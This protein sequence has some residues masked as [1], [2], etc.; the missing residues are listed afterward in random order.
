MSKKLLRAGIIVFVVSIIS[1]LLGFSKETL[2]A[3]IYGT[4]ISSDAYYI[5]LTPSTLAITFSLSLSG[6]FIPLFIR[7]LDQRNGAFRFLN[8]VLALF[9]FFTLILYAGLFLFQH[10]FLDLIAPGIPVEQQQLYISL[11]KIMFP[12][13]YIV[14]AV[15]IYTVVLN[16]MKSF[17]LPAI[18]ILPSNLLIILYLEVFK[19]KLGL[20][21]V[22]YATLISNVIQYV[23]LYFALKKYDYKIKL[24]VKFFDFKT[25]EFLLLLLPILM[26]TS[27]S[28][29]SA[30]VDRV[31]ASGLGE[32]SVSSL[33]YS[34]RLRGLATGVFITSIITVTFPKAAE[35]AHKL[36]VKKLEAFTKKCMVALIYVLAP[37]TIFFMV[38]SKEI[39]NLLFER[40]KFDQTATAM[41]SGIFFTYSIGLVAI[42]FREVAVRTFYTFKDTKTP[43]FIMVIS[44]ML[45]IVLSVVFTRFYGL[46]G[47]GLSASLSFI[48]TAIVMGYKLPKRLPNLWSKDF[49]V[50]HIKALCAFVISYLI[51]IFVRDSGAI[52][53]FHELNGIEKLIM[54]GVYFALSTV[55]FMLV[56]LV[57]REEHLMGYCKTIWMSRR[58]K[59]QRRDEKVENIN[60]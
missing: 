11:L 56:L 42:G 47:L 34:F 3:A 32:G 39:I 8:N 43:T 17:L 40:G 44:L 54:L 24:P 14:I 22:A 33:M 38:F 26:S 51:I 23:I 41:T 12:L 20:T 49:V 60:Y 46:Q 35:M 45:N 13:I 31:L 19:D 25:K 4:S 48:F 55:V 6:I 10:Q 2:I 5:A 15:Q 59:V 16:S 58:R 7:D 18:S 29:I 52:Q 36:E 53:S 30:I 9:F 28:Q 1:K 50:F 21:G 37:L 57:I 27:F